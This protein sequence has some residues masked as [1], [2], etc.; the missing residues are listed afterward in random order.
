LPA[1]QKLCREMRRSEGVIRRFGWCSVGR[2]SDRRCTRHVTDAKQ[3]LVVRAAPADHRSTTEQD[4]LR[5]ALRSRQLGHNQ[6]GHRRLDE[7]AGTRLD[8][9]EDVGVQTLG[10]RRAETLSTQRTH[11]RT[12]TRALTQ[13]EAIF[14]RAPAQRRRNFLE[15][16]RRGEAR[17]AESGGWGSWEGTASPSPPTRGLA[18]A[19]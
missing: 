10:R 2:F 17:R 15:C 12:F 14:P 19:L 5:A 8:H 1:D 7:R 4:R 18:G 6:S 3:K 11:A 9:D 16:G 13:L